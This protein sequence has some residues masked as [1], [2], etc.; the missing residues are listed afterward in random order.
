YGT[1]EIVGRV[2]RLRKN[3]SNQS[4]YYI[5]EFDVVVSPKRKAFKWAVNIEHAT[6]E[7]LKNSI[8][9]INQTPA[10]EN[11]AVV[12]NF[13]NDGDRYLPRN[14]ASFREILRSLVSK[15]NH[16]FTVF[17]ETPSKPFNSWTFPKV[18]EL[19]GL[20]DDPN[21]SIDV[22]PVFHCG[23]VDLGSKAVVK[24]LMAE[25][26]LRQEVTPL[27]KAYEATKTIYSYSY[28]ATG[29]SLYKDNFKLIPEKLIEGR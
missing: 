6:L 16:K 27:D 18:C 17:I 12:F 29:V 4:L 25:L 21:P 9:A 1:Y 7:G 28:L 19:Y 14:D 5:I 26:R 24:H 13:M 15:N 2:E 23:C 8:R 11:P 10:L 22:Y 20:S 3:I